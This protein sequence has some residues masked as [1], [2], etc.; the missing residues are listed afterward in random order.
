VVRTSCA[1]LLL[2]AATLAAPVS[3]QEDLDLDAWHESRPSL[4]ADREPSS[5]PRLAL[6]LYPSAGVVLGLPDLA[7][8]AADVAVSVTARD[9][10]SAFAGYGREWGPHTDSESYTLGWGGVRPLR[11]ASGGQRGFHGVFLRYRRWTHDDHGRHHG[12]SAGLES[13][14]GHL[15]LAL[16]IGVARSDRDHW[17]P[18]A[19]VT[20][21]LCLPVLVPLAW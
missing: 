17:L 14:A 6:G 19:R 21:K 12:L 10:F 20:V 13:G 5:R 2:L 11:V 8:G 16:E 1:A 3:G 4:A 9:R 18:A 15:G 7:A